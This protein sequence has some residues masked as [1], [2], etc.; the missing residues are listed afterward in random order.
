MCIRDRE[1]TGYGAIKMIAPK[2]TAFNKSKLALLNTV[3]GEL[4]ST[5]RT[6]DT[7]QETNSNLSHAT[8]EL[9]ALT[10]FTR[11]VSSSQEVEEIA[12]RLLVTAQ[13]LTSADHGFVALFPNIQAEDRNDAEEVFT[14]AHYP[15]ELSLIHISE[16]T[17]P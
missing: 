6:A 5:L 13:K 7:Y 9:T 1:N 16:P 15:Q 8:Q 2:G 4:A 3:S 14:I 10:S 11:K 12:E 17:R